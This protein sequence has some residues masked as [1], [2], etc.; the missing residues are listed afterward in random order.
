MFPERPEPT[1]QVV[2]APRAERYGEQRHD[3]GEPGPISDEAAPESAAETDRTGQSEKSRSSQAREKSSPVMRRSLAAAKAA[4]RSARLF[5]RLRGLRDSP[6]SD[7]GAFAAEIEQTCLAHP[8]R[9]RASPH[10]VSVPRVRRAAPRWAAPI[11][12]RHK[13]LAAKI[14]KMVQAEQQYDQS[15]SGEY[16]AGGIGAAQIGV[17]LDPAGID[18]RQQG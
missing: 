18:Q 11:A 16:Q 8:G 17:T 2:D 1:N 12:R 4:S 6:Q 7:G 9:P 3:I 10:S 14:T 13:G 15:E 5:D